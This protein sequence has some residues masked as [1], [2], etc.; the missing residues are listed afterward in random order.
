[1]WNALPSRKM[2]TATPIAYAKAVLHT[3]KHATQ[4]VMGF[5]LGRRL[6]GG[7][8]AVFVADAVPVMHSGFTVMPSPVIDAAH[9][10]C[11]ASSKTQGLTVVGLYAA[12]ERADDNAVSD[13]TKSLVKFLVSKLPSGG[14]MVLWNLNNALLKDGDVPAASVSVVDSNGNS[15]SGGDMKF[16]A[17]NTGSCGADSVSTPEAL[18]VVASLTDAFAHASLVDFEEHLEDPQLDFFNPKLH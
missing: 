17:W 11:S 12:N 4:P 6:Q 13:H 8:D 10:L 7:G 5:L 14:C 15:S 18:Q 16:G 1:M 2:S 3:K 9:D